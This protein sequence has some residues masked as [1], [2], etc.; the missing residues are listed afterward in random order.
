VS[1]FGS[2]VME[3]AFGKWRQHPSLAFMMEKDILS[4]CCNTDDV[5]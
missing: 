1:R 5:M 2:A 4:T 3:P